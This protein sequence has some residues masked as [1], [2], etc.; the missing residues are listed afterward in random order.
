MTPSRPVLYLSLFLSAQQLCRAD[1]TACDGPDGGIENCC[2]GVSSTGICE[3]CKEGYGLVNGGKGCAKCKDPA[4][5]SCNESLNFCKDS[6][7]FKG[8]IPNC[9]LQ[10]GNTCIYVSVPCIT[11]IK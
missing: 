8:K 1:P 7:K 10:S 11:F 2:F 3:Y 5:L 9:S 4:C 6:E